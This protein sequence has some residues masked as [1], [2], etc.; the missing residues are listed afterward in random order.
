MDR[1]LRESAHFITLNSAEPNKK[2][3]MIVLFGCE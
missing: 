2:F 1:P 3:V